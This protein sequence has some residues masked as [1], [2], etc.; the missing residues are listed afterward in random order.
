MTLINYENLKKFVFNAFSAM[1]LNKKDAERQDKE[2]Y[3]KA[4]DK[5][6]VI[7]SAINGAACI[8]FNPGNILVNKKS[9]TVIDWEKTADIQA[10]MAAYNV[11]TPK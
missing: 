11:G 3:K 9:T 2:K 7:E 8:R 6:S 1:G 5:H 10:K 4:K